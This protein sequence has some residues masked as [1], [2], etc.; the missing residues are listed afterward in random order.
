MQ[1]SVAMN[2]NKNVFNHRRKFIY[3]C[4]YFIHV[5]CIL[6]RTYAYRQRS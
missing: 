1:S 3:E 5:R 4:G 6:S 2:R